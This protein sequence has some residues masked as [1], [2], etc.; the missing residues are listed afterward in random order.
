MF[1]DEIEV[2]RE[3]SV[4]IHGYI[5]GCDVCVVTFVDPFACLSVVF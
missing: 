2:K 5:F 3:V 4:Y 1:E